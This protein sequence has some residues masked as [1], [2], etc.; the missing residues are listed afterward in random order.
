MAD[1][2][3][4]YRR[5]LQEYKGAVVTYYGISPAYASEE[6]EAAMV[7]ARK[8]LDAYVARLVADAERLRGRLESLAK[9]WTTTAAATGNPG[10]QTALIWCANELDD[11]R[12][13]AGDEA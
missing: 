7:N 2:M 11:A 12:Q 5:L 4:E 9:R 10:K 8:E 1:E 6:A 3:S 13:E